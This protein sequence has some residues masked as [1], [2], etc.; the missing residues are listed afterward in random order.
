LCGTRSIGGR[1]IPQMLGAMARIEM[2]QNGKTWSQLYSAMALRSFGV[3]LNSNV[4]WQ[5]MTP[6]ERNT[7]RTLLY[8]A[9]FYNAKSH[10][11]I[12][13]TELYFCVAASNAAIDYQLGIIKD[14]TALDDLLSRA[15]KQFTDGA[16][17]AADALPTGR[18]DRY[19]N[20]YAKA[21]YEAGEIAG[22]QDIVRYE[23]FLQWNLAR[24]LP[25]H[26]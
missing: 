21:I 1:D 20:E 15:A 3:N 19:S 22:R 12:N 6:E 17:F 4:L 13:L 7:Y 18:Y 23:P 11:L 2:R 25:L 24:G 14:R 16:L 26:L 9:R 10:A 8:P 5:S